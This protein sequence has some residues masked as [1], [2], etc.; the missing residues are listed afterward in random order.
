MHQLSVV[1]SP[2]VYT[3]KFKLVVYILLLVLCDQQKYSEK[4]EEFIG[5]DSYILNHL[6][7]VC[8]YISHF[9]TSLLKLK[10]SL[11]KKDSCR[12]WLVG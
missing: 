10:I 9:M 5:L 8:I 1:R 12:F 7:L 2:P 11:V 3:F 6:N 4:S